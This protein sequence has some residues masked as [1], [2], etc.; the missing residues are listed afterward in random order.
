VPTAPATVSK[1]G[2][3]GPHSRDQGGRQCSAPAALL[4]DQQERLVIT[5]NHFAELMKFMQIEQKG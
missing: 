4:C 5:I 2:S 1:G 3:I